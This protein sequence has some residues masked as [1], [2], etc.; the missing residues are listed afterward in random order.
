MHE[1]AHSSIFVIE[2]II[3]IT[4]KTNTAKMFKLIMFNSYDGVL[5]F[6]IK[7]RFFKEYLMT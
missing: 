5:Q 6:L 7:I 1:V 2:K 4:E 3:K